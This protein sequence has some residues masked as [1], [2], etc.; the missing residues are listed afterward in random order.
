MI[1]GFSTK[2]IKSEKTLSERLK[3]A[4]VRQKISLYEAEIGSKVRAKYLA[5]IEE[6]RWNELPQNVYARSFV[7]AYAKFLKLDLKLM[8]ELCESEMSFRNCKEQQ[9]I[10]YNQSFKDKKVLITPK[11]IGYSALAISIISVITYIAFQLVGFAGNP[12]LK[13]TSP[14]NNITTDND[15]VDLAGVTDVDTVVSINGES[16]PVSNDGH[17]L[18]KLKLHQGVNMVKVK[19]TNKAKKESAQIYTVEYKPKTAAIENNIN[20]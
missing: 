14:D 11:L 13:I 9:K 1:S 16:V 12:D 4:R 8:K 3:M 6:G 5:A 18:T 20:Q 7:L 2:K 10:S 19:A 17:F 15:S